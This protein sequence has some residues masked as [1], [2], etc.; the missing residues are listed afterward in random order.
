MSAL[1]T[2]KDLIW[3]IK[4]L[5]N[6]LPKSVPQGSSNDKLWTVM[7]GAER[8][9]AFETFNGR[10]DALFGED[11]RDLNGR[12]Y[13]LRRGKF[14]M[15]AVCNY[16]SEVNWAGFPLDLVEIKLLRLIAELKYIMYDYFLILSFI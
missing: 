8:E 4:S 14:G 16:I 15:G 12:L 5:S 2:V 3:E 10:F 9:T 1:N 7:N 13:H 6:S 11:C